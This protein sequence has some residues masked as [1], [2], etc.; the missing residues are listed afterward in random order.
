MATEQD[1]LIR[2][3]VNG[4]R[5]TRARFQG[6]R[7]C[8]LSV[9][10]RYKNTCVTTRG[11]LV[12]LLWSAVL[13]PLGF[14]A[15]YLFTTVQLFLNVLS[16]ATV[17]YCCYIIALLLYPVAAVVSQL[18]WTRFKSLLVGSLS[19]GM[20]VVLILILVLFDVVSTK[21]SYL[22]LVP[23]LF[24]VSGLALFQSNILQYGTDQ[25][26]FASSEVLSSFAFWYYWTCFLPPWGALLPTTL[27]LANN[28][29]RG[30]LGLALLAVIAV[31]F[32]FLVCITVC[33]CYCHRE[34]RMNHSDVHD[35]PVRLIWGVV[36]FATKKKEHIFRSAFTYNEMPSRLDLAKQR[37]GGPFTT[38]E[39]EDVKSFWQLLTLLISLIGFQLRDDT[40]FLSIESVGFYPNLWTPADFPWNVP[41]L[42]IVVCIPVY[43]L[44]IRPF[45]SKYIPGML[46]RMK[47]GLV[48]VLLSLLATTVIS[49]NVLLMNERETHYFF[50]NSENQFCD[51]HIC[52]ADI[53][54]N[55]STK[56]PSFRSVVYQDWNYYECN[57]TDG[58]VH[59]EYF[60]YSPLSEP[61]I[62]WLLRIPQALN[63][64]ANM[65]VFLTV[66]EFIFAQ[67]PQRMQ[68]L[69]VGLWY[70]L[71]SINVA[72]GITGYFSCITFYWQYY[73]IKTVLFFLSTLLFLCVSRKYKYRKL[74]EDIDVNIQQEIE[75]AFERNF[76]REAEYERKQLQQQTLYIVESIIN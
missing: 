20:G 49:E 36:Q 12:A 68:G 51:V 11:G 26:D 60:L 74:D 69:L 45:F 13:N 71:Q 67:A 37:Y 63:G 64:L 25:L 61:V 24:V 66:L 16:L 55:F 32:L 23:L 57:I 3:W 53:I 38:R 59:H 52:T 35:N 62:S 40:T 31:V 15:V 6:R 18:R 76:D 4:R 2:V 47:I 9:S 39:V 5:D 7:R 19:V 41:A 33:C 43:Q 30:T 50:N 54:G 73:A 58:C 44:V 42:V 14:G 75:Q 48:F 8:P 27:L 21:L 28:A 10:K 56:T 70:A 34:V 17:A 72:I 29:D 1:P 22:Y 46:T 65:L